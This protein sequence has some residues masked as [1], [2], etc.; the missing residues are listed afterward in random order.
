MQMGGFV[1]YGQKNLSERKVKSRKTVCKF[2]VAA[3]AND[4]TFS[5]FKQQKCILSPV[6]RPEVQN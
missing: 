1:C 3:T 6:W 5:G 2:P 4:L